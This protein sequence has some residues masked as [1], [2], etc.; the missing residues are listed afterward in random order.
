IVFNYLYLFYLSMSEQQLLEDIAKGE[1]SNEIKPI[2]PPEEGQTE[3]EKIETPS[4]ENKGEE[5][6]AEEGKIEQM[7][8]L[9]EGE[10]KKEEGEVKKDD[11]PDEFSRSVKSADFRIDDGPTYPERKLWDRMFGKVSK[12][13]LRVAIVEFTAFTIGVGCLTFPYVISKVGFVPGIILLLFTKIA[14]IL[15]LYL[16]LEVGIQLKNNNYNDIARKCIGRFWLAIYDICNIVN[17]LGVIMSYLTTI[18]NMV[19]QFTKMIFDKDITQW[20]MYVITCFCINIP[21]CLIKDLSLLQIPSLVATISIS[22]IILTVAIETPFY[23]MQNREDDKDIEWLKPISTS[24]FDC[25]ASF[26]FA[27][28]NQ[29]TILM[30]FSNIDKPT[31][32]RGKKIVDRSNIFI[33]ILYCLVG[34]GG[35]VSSLEDTPDIYIG[36]PNLRS[37]PKDYPNTIT[38]VVLAICLCSIIPLKWNIY[39]ESIKSLFQIK[40]IPKKVDIPMT[41]IGMI[42]L[43][44]LVYFTDIITIIGFIGGIFT[45]VI[46]FLVPV[47]DYFVV[48]PEERTS[49]RMIVAYIV[50]AIFTIVGAIA[51]GKS[52]YEFIKG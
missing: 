19:T 7:K 2:E 37:F 36:R 14:N 41:I 48:F 30:V 10:E 15:M 52:V 12:G 17:Y 9:E 6:K 28:S 23:V 46:S 34:F 35:Y 49:I 33:L 51:S 22:V 11:E 5:G 29:N 18:Y 47:F 16:V 25:L 38:K 50:L 1:E 26:M 31:Y 32:R 13:A 8:P 21:L 45:V 27:Y 20:I 43:N 42:C 24:Y 3:G 40:E 39:R 44:V 4:D